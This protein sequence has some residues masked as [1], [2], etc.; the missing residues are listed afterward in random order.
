MK[1]TECLWIDKFVDKIIRKHNI[2]PEEVEEVFSKK[3]LIRRIEG[4]NVK[5]EDLFVSFGR[6]NAGRYLSVL[7]VRKRNKR[8][9]VIS[10][11]DM[12]KSERKRYGKK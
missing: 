5:G 6:T 7:F 4:G 10:A 11:R 12:T 2:Y 8:A 9:L 3:P 1:I